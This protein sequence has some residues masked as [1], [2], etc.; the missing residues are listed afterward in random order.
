MVLIH[1][2]GCC[3]RDSW[4]PLGRL[5]GR[6]SEPL[7]TSSAPLGAVTG[8]FESLWGYLRAILEH[9]GGVYQFGCY[10]KHSWKLLGRLFGRSSEPLRT[11][12]GPLWAV[13]GHFGS[14]LGH[15]RAIL[16][17]LGEVYQKGWF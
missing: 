13:S 16:G 11:S 3:L 4:R 7:S 10:L 17:H 14:L 8:H 5:L 6:S 1:L 15:L 2:S 9:L 12:S